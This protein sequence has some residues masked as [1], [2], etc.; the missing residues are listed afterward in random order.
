MKTFAI[1]ENLAS[2]VLTYLATRPYREVYELVAALQQMQPV[3]EPAPV[4]PLP[5]GVPPQG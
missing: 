2:A 3:G 1:P 4:P 5:P